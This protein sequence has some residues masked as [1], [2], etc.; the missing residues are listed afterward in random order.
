[1]FDQRY[2]L[3]VPVPFIG[4]HSAHYRVLL[5][6]I[7]YQNQSGTTI[8]RF[9]ISYVQFCEKLIRLYAQVEACAPVVCWLRANV[10]D[11]VLPLV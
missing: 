4:H 10:R 9:S 6:D 8:E 5:D 11:D 2:F 7:Y 3:S 1:M